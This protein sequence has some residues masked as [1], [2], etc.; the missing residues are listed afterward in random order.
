MINILATVER[1][2]ASFK[3]NEKKWIK[4]GTRYNKKCKVKVGLVRWKTL[5]TYCTMMLIT[6]SKNNLIKILF[7]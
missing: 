6:C 1:L 4:K 3:C 7:G 2:K 5:K